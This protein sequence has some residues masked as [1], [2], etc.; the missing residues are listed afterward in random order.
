M[1]Q[2]KSFKI[3]INNDT[4]EPAH[5]QIVNQ[6]TGAIHCGL[7][8]PGDQIPSISELS[9]TL[10]LAPMTISKA[11]QRLRTDGYITQSRGGPTLVNTS[12]PVDIAAEKLVY[13]GR[14]FQLTNKQ[15]VNS[16]ER[17]MGKNP[18]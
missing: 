6:I 11:F 12:P 10:H 8:R 14:Q 16:L 17:A 5:L 2:Q 3:A 7:L 9:T 4:T 15:I 18:L 13:I 1:T